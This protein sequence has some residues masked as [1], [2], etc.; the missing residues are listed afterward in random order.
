MQTTDRTR[1]FLRALR[2][3]ALR[4]TTVAQRGY[5]INSEISRKGAKTQRAQWKKCHKFGVGGVLVTKA[6]LS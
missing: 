3:Y 6:F 4:E 1:V 2:L 5:Q